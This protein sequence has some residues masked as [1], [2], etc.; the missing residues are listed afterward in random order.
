M[1]VLFD[2]T[3]SGSG[4]NGATLWIDL[5][6]IPSG[7]D[8]RIGQWTV[9]GA[10]TETFYLYTNTIGKSASGTTNCTLLAQI[11]PKAGATTTQDLYKNG[12]LYTKTVLSTG[13]EHWWLYISS[14]SSTAAAYNYKVLYM[15][16]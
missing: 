15:Q 2:K 10:K 1:A 12:S 8:F 6:L 16:E 11:A 13:V 4:S 14:K 7:F 9:Y 3:V 5:G